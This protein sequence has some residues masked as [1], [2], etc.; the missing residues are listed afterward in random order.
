M[1]KWVRRMAGEV[2][3]GWWANGDGRQA[4]V[5][6]SEPL[7]AL[8]VFAP[9]TAGGLGDW[10]DEALCACTLEEARALVAGLDAYDPAGLAELRRR[11]GQ[12]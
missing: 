2:D 7:G 8:Y 6:W 12:R 11:A 4:R 9:L 3:L 1:A 10:T 5:S